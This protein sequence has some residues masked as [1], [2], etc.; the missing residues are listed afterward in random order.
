M[1]TTQTGAPASAPTPTG[2]HCRV[3]VVAPTSRVDV[4]LPE[5]APLAELL[6][7]IL[8]LVGG[9][10]GVFGATTW[11]D[12][13]TAR[14]RAP[15]GPTAHGLTGHVLTGRDGIIF[16]AARTLAEQGVLHGDLLRL[17]TV[18]DLPEAP[19]HDDVV[20]AV[21]EAVLA[22]GRPWTADALR[23]ATL[24][25]VSLHLGLAAVVLWLA[26]ARFPG[27]FHG[28]T[29]AIAGAAALFLVTFGIWRARYDGEPGSRGSYY[30]AP[31][32]AR[33]SWNSWNSFTPSPSS[34]AHSRRAAPHRAPSHSTTASS[35]SSRHSQAHSLS[36]PSS[37][38]GDGLRD[39]TVAAVLTTCSLPFAFVAGFGVLPTSTWH[40]L[41]RTQFTVGALAV[42]VF[43]VASVLGL[44]RRIVGAVAGATI[45]FIGLA[46]GVGLVASHAAPMTAIAVAACCCVF[47]IDGLPSLAMYLAGF[48]VEPPVSVLEAG[49]F[50]GYPVNNELVAFRTERSHDTLTGLTV[51]IGIVLVACVALLVVPSAAMGT[52][53]RG[54][55]TVWTQLLGLVLAGAA[56]CRTR[57]FHLRTQVVAL[58]VTTLA[59]LALVVSAVAAQASPD[60]RST[61]LAWSLFAGAAL[62]LPLSTPRRRATTAPT[63]PPRWSRAIDLAEG[64]LHLA[65]LPVLLAAL[66][67]YGQARSLHG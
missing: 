10:A 39:H 67:V 3:T 57:L 6:P 17:R 32:H 50:D 7:E 30:G 58:L 62:A 43:A 35:R 45:G 27:S 25:V 38:R 59:T 55:H 63:I 64:V 19:V 26:G 1:T 44:G 4:A 49:D 23:T 51:G 37:L 56:L 47:A 65:I 60:T 46:V 33:R 16:D 40:G 42:F 61:W 18:D 5:D 34:G 66:G 12:H 31:S 53:P 11:S 36:A 2:G 54:P 8:R 14:N 24:V 21:A 15:Y 20:D 29:A 28:R 48:V 41:G 13:P 52:A 9:P 22:D